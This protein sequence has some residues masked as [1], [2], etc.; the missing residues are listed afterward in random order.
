MGWQDDF[1]LRADLRV[2]DMYA[3]ETALQELGGIRTG[4]IANASHLLKAAIAAGWIESPDC[5]VGEFDG[6][7]RYFLAGENVDDMVPGVAFW[8]G[9]KIGECYTN[10]MTIPKN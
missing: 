10:A 8:Y 9:S 1:N 3:F 5:E 4:N 7:T 2:S 6:E